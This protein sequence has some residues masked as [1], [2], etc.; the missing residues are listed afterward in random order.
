M[1]TSAGIAAGSVPGWNSDF[2][3]FTPYYQPIP[4]RPNSVSGSSGGGASG[5]TTISSGS[6]TGVPYTVGGGVVPNA[7]ALEAQS[8]MD[9]G[10]LLNPGNN[11]PDVNRQAAELSAGRGIP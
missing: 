8:S 4:T 10:Q 1:P 2:T 11:F 6:S 9:I 5:V 7:G 3:Q